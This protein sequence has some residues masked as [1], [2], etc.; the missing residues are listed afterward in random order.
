MSSFAILEEPDEPTTT[1]K[2]KGN[3]CFSEKLYEDAIFHYT[4]AIDNFTKSKTENN[5]YNA[6]LYNNRAM[7]FSLV[8]KHG[9]AINDAKK[10][11]QL[12]NTNPKFYFRLSHS[13]IAI[14]NYTSA[15]TQA[16]E[17]LKME[18]GNKPLLKLKREAM[19]KI[20]ESKVSKNTLAA[21]EANKVKPDK[22]IN[23]GSLYSDK[24]GKHA[25]ARAI[26][27]QLKSELS[28][29]KINSTH[30]SFKGIFSKLMNP[31][32]FQQTIFPGLS[33]EARQT[34]PKSLHELL[35]N[36]TYEEEMA[37]NG[38]PDARKKA[39]D[40]LERYVQTKYERSEERMINEQ[41]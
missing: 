13:L 18:E 24:N 3:E 34:A 40:V 9:R 25:S 29:G 31:E 12:D 26:I 33:K 23:L 8:G 11:I 7:C 1:S 38:I 41:R 39:T 17:G 22:Q 27:D 6:V 16:E 21:K 15:K 4:D 36:K 20:K 14:K 28:S 30:N 32:T 5:P 19:I 10:A 2:S 37:K 35:E